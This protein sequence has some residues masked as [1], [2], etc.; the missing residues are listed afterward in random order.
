[1]GKITFS[2]QT[3]RSTSRLQGRTT[4]TSSETSTSARSDPT[5]RATCDQYVSL[6]PGISSCKTS[7]RIGLHSAWSRR[8]SANEAAVSHERHETDG[9]GAGDGRAELACRHQEVA[10]S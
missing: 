3:Y 10:R 1:M 2:P 7:I 6:M 9:G 8:G 5:N 4:A